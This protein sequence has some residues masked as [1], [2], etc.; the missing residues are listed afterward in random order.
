MNNIS[1]WLGGPHTWVGR[2]LLTVEQLARV[3]TSPACAHVGQTGGGQRVAVSQMKQGMMELRMPVATI[4]VQLGRAHGRASAGKKSSVFPQFLQG[5]FQ[6]LTRYSA[7]KW[8]RMSCSDGLGRAEWAWST[9]PVTSRSDSAPRTDWR[10]SSIEGPV[11]SLRLATGLPTGRPVMNGESDRLG[12][13]A[14][15]ISIILLG[16]RST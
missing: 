3:H 6:S 1:N 8:A 10:Q 9:K 4:P 13:M 2:F 7:A 14:S 15:R 12:I 11:P 16:F 5:S